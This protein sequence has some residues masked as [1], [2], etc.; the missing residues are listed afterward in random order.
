MRRHR[1]RRGRL[2][3]VLT[4]ADRLVL[5]VVVGAALV[6][7]LTPSRA[8]EESVVR[9]TG[10]GGFERVLGLTVDDTLTVAGPL[11][12]TVIEVRGGEA[13]VVS[14]P[15]PQK[16]CVKMG[17]AGEPGESA[18]CVPNRVVVTVVGGAMPSTDAVTR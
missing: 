9:V 16:L 14:S 1:G 6:L 18:V 13:R 8:G 3:F 17:S 4:W 5:Y 11:G 15:C 10:D 7:L 2:R 12:D